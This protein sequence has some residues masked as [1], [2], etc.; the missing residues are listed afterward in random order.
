L[1]LEIELDGLKVSNDVF[2]PMIKNVVRQ[3]LMNSGVLRWAG[4]L[5]GRGAAIL[6]YHSVV[7][8][9][10]QF[11]DS[12]GAI[13]HS[14]RVFQEQ[15]EL[16][17]REFTPVDLLQIREF[18][19]G[20]RDLPERAVAI[21]FDDG[22][23][24]NHEM[25]MPILNRLGIPAAFY[26]TVDCIE[27]RKLPWPSRLRFSFRKTR[28]TRFVDSNGEAWDLSDA[29]QRE[30]AYLKV[31]DRICA[32]AGAPLEEAVAGIEQQL[33]ARLPDETG[34]LMMTWR[35]A[36]DLAQSGHIM[37]SHTMTHP[38]LAFLDSRDVHRE[39][40]ESKRSMEERIGCAIEHFSYPC[41]AL[42]PNWTEQTLEE[43]RRVGYKTAVTT[44]NGLTRAKD[45]ILG[46]KRV[47]PSKTVEGLRWN[48]E[49][50]FAG[51][52]S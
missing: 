26:I 52:A 29:A 15:M 21:T 9:P 33:D 32:L 11:S 22:Y 23:R 12:L 14:T 17:A 1:L 19:E 28:Q 42:F 44:T 35:Q 5:R 24:D 43:S 36:K 3:V 16:L 40:A 37:G 8:D 4:R 45:N 31:C 13:T 25:A 7:D 47:R 50:A 30:S 48:L 27:R 2:F 49:S 46:L 39:L 18:L 41:P 20:T 38:N 51:R 34:D 6:M 10:K